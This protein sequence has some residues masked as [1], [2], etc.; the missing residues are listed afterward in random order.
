MTTWVVR[1]A[2]G[3]SQRWDVEAREHGYLENE[4]NRLGDCPWWRGVKG[5]TQ[6][7]GLAE[8]NHLSA[9]DPE[10][11]FWSSRSHP[12][13]CP[14]GRRTYGTRVQRRSEN[15]FNIR[16]MV[17]TWEEAGRK[18]PLPLPQSK[19]QEGEA[20][21]PPC[22]DMIL[23]FPRIGRSWS[24]SFEEGLRTCQNRREGKQEV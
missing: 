24:Y 9:G 12:G 20:R 17:T 19:T 14:E 16:K 21:P 11:A 7:P 13:K 8:H 15:G 22:S 3:V 10:E 5:N 18:P 4:V 6:P 1:R 2:T 23:V